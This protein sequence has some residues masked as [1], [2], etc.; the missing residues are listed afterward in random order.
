[1]TWFRSS[2][3][4]DWEIV[5]KLGHSPTTTKTYKIEDF[6]SVEEYTKGKTLEKP[7]E[8]PVGFISWTI[9]FS[10]KFLSC[11]HAN[12]WCVT[13]KVCKTTKKNCVNCEW[14]RRMQG[15]KRWFYL[16]STE[17]SSIRER[18]RKFLANIHRNEEEKWSVTLKPG[19]FSSNFEENR[20]DSI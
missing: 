15:E 5:D 7:H 17:T 12:P 10:R 16:E 8:A 4:L 18:K 11:D 3:K 14:S 1:M 20:N 13:I 2:G 9:F 19:D 6:Y